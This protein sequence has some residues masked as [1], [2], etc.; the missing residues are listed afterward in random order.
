MT[1]YKSRGL[2][3][4]AIIVN[5]YKEPRILTLSDA[6]EI[7]RNSDKGIDWIIFKVMYCEV[8]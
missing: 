8:K 3:G 1:W 2:T 7:L 4:S 5:D 6:E